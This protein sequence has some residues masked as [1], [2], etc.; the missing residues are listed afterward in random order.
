MASVSAYPSVKDHITAELRGLLYG[1]TLKVGDRVAIDEIAE[2][3]G[4]SRT[5]VRDAVFA[6]SQ[7]GLLVIEPR[8][9][10]FVRPITNEEVLDV[11]R[12]KE[13]LEPLVARLATERSTPQERSDQLQAVKLLEAAA[14]ERNVAL[15]VDLLEQRREMLLAMARSEALGDC[16]RTIDGRVRF[17]RSRNLSQI[18][19]LA[20]SAQQ[21]RLIAEAIYS[22]DSSGAAIAMSLHNRD[23][24]RR[25]L[26]LVA[27]IEANELEFTSSYVE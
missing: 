7:E 4:V 6:L 17:L 27:S 14:E 12:I 13:A 26:A 5:P 18:G 1:G 24:R 22:D 2:R 3:F 15:Y 10:V 9:G 16:L 8:V 20:A 21:H 23:A 11:Y 25:I 19:Y